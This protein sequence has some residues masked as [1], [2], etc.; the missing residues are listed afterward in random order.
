MNQQATIVTDP[1]AIQRISRSAI[2]GALKLEL[3]GLRHSRNAAR[4]GAA[5]LL[6]DNGVKP[7]RTTKALFAQFQ[8]LRVKLGDYEAGA[9]RHILPQKKIA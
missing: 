2:E 6:T 9:T 5:K 1:D 8:E 4:L 7:K 3:V